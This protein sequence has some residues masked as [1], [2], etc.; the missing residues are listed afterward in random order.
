[1]DISTKKLAF[2]G[3]GNMAE[4]LIKGLLAAG[5]VPPGHVVVS[6]VRGDRLKELERLYGVRTEQDNARA[7]EGCD[8]VVLAVKPQ[9][10][11]E[12]LSGLKAVA[13]RFNPLMISIAAGVPTVRIEQVLGA[14]TRVVRVMPNTPALVGRGAAALCAGSRAGAAD[15]DLAEEILSA[16]GIAVR[17]DEKDM[18]AVTAVSGSGPAYVFVLM[19]AM[20]QVA[21]EHD[22]DAQQARALVI[23]TVEGAAAL[24]RASDVGPAELRQRVTSPGGTTAATLESFQQ[25]GV[26]E[27]LVYGIH[28]AAERSRELSQIE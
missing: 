19:E 15:M 27:A 12:V 4:A 23:Q 26:Y 3:G 22:M 14:A 6:D 20:E 13:N 24:Y 9:Q 25:Q 2:I 10:F 11:D 21:R 16:V 8:A 7:V 17:V 5:R 18:D 1:M 28:K